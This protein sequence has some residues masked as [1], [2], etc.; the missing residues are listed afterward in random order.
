[1]YD[2]PGNVRELENRVKRAVVMCEGNFVVS[3]DLE[4]DASRDS[5]I[6]KSLR[7]IREET[8]KYHVKKA[9]EKHEI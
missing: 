7:Q 9:L 5:A 2:W 1:L 4:L 8:E 3:G 6:P